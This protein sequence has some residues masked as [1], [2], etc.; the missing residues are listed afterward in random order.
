MKRIFLCFALFFL[1]HLPID[2]FGSEI[3]GPEIRLINNEVMVTTGLQ[4]DDKIFN[5]LK[6]GIS[7]EITFYIDL[8]KV[9]NVWPDEFISGRKFVRTLK[10]DPIKKE[11]IA[12]SFDGVTLTERRFKSIDSM[13]A[14]TLNIRDLKLTIAKDREPSDYIIKVTAEAKLIEL[15]SVIG[16]LLFF[17]PEKDFKLSKNSPTFRAKGLR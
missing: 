11:H 17:V 9:W 10:S 15:P 6:N 4:L 13:I 2:L 14:W 5:E 1:L 16:H 12:T 7:K 3:T 8:F